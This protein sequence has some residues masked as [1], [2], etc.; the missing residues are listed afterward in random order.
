MSWSHYV[1]LLSISDDI[2]RSF[3]EKQ[4][5]AEKWSVREL[6]RQRNASLFERIALSRD[7]NEVAAL[8]RQG[9]IIETSR[10]II[11]I[12]MYLNSWIYRKKASIQNALWKTL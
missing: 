4:C 12:P 8:A 3:Y 5:I 2:S 10:D 6:K 7:K 9:Q 1:E 11:K